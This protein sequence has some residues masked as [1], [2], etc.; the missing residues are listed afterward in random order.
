MLRLLKGRWGILRSPSWFS[1]KTHSRIVLA[2]VLLHNL[3][4][5]YMPPTSFDDDGMFEDVASDSH[6]ND[7]SDEE[8]YITSIDVS[9]PW[10]NFRNTLAQNMFNNWRARHH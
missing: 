10:T 6:D 8:E 5:R 4:K 1:L 9:D 2:C 3:V 7:E